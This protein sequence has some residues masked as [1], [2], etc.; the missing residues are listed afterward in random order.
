M[1]TGRLSRTPAARCS[2]AWRSSSTPAESRR[3]SRATTPTRSRPGSTCSPSGSRWGCAPG[4]PRSTSR[5]WCRCG[6]TRW[7]SPAATRSCSSPANATRARRCWSPS[8]GR[9]PACPTGCSTWCTGDKEAVDALLDHPDVAA[10][11][12]VGSTPIARYIHERGTANGKRVQALG[13]AKNHADHPAGRGHRLRVG[14][15]GRGRIRFGRRAL[16]GHLGRGGHRL[17]G[18]RA[19]RRGEREG[20]G[21]QGRPGPRRG[22]RDGPGH[23][24]GRPRP[25]RRADRHRRRAGR[26]PRRR[27]PGADRARTRERFLRRPDGDRQRHPGHGRLPRGDL[28][29]GAVGGPGRLGGRGHRT[30]QRQPLRQRHRHLHLLRGGGAPVP[31][32]GERRA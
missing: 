19:G 23:H 1:S 29:A 17:R 8:C 13:G 11:S 10:V 2:A 12:F 26:H 28:R 25:H 27:R 21:D 15:P 9:R 4:S 5:P 3:R 24:R 31:A 22:Q 7:P 18:R 32:R 30:D 6:C 14:S 20:P 16:H